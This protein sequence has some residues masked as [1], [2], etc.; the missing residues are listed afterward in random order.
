[1]VKSLRKKREEGE[2]VETLPKISLI[3]KGTKASPAISSILLTLHKFRSPNSILLSKRHENLFPF[4]HTEVIEKFVSQKDASLFVI[5]SNSKKRPNNLIFGRLFDSEMLDLVEF[6]VSEYEEVSTKH[7]FPPGIHPLIL[8]QGE[9]FETDSIYSRVKS[10]FLDFFGGKALEKV[11]TRGLNK[12]FTITGAENN[13][14][15]FR[16]YHLPEMEE[17]GAKFTLEL[18]RSRIAPDDKFKT[19]CTEVKLKKKVKN[20]E[21]NP[22]R[23]KR[24]RVHVQQQDIKTIALKKR[25][26]KPNPES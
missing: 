13:K 21:T 25:K 7:A 22:L 14:I 3:L 9:I 4:E 19:A 17:V 15:Y 18:K 26:P 16:C 23:E 1:M 6:N 11:D 10:I 20:I 5:G 2:I 12:L 24:G 8:F